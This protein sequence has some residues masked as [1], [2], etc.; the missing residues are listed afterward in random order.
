[1]SAVQETERMKREWRLH[2]LVL[3]ALSGMA[4]L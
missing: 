1:M 3:R 2:P 4:F